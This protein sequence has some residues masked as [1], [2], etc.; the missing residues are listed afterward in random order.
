[1]TKQT[2]TRK[3]DVRRQTRYGSVEYIECMV[4]LD[5]DID[6]IMRWLGAKALTNRSKKTKALGGDVLVRVRPTAAGKLKLDQR[7]AK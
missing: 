7:T 1:M 3:L 6:F 5:I 4:E 2:F